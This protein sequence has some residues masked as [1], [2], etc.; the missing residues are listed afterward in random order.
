MAFRVLKHIENIAPGEI[1][2]CEYAFTNKV[3]FR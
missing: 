1:V 3:K 2:E